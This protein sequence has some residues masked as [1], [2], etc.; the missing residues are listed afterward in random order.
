MILPTLEQCCRQA[1][2]LVKLEQPGP[3]LYAIGGA[4]GQN[5]PPVSA[6]STAKSNAYTAK[7]K[8]ESSGLDSGLS[9]ERNR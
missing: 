6:H 9:L 7:R 8:P 5:A 1:V 3:L 2:A 4:H